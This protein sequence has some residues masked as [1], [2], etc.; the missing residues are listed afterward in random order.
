MSEIITEEIEKKVLEFLIFPETLQH[1]LEDT[2]LP[3][4]ILQDVI[5]QLLRKGLVNTV[6][7]TSGITAPI[8]IYYDSDHM[9]KFAYKISAKGMK[10][11]GF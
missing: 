8:E 2:K 11:M 7:N 9:H 4:N 3:K 6:K 10:E 5:K 1:L